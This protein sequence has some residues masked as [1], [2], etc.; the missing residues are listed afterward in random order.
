M[1]HNARLLEILTG[2]ADLDGLAPKPSEG[3]AERATA[4][5]P[6]GV[7]LAMLLSALDG[8]EPGRAST[9]PSRARSRRACASDV[10]LEALLPFA[11]QRNVLVKVRPLQRESGAVTGAIASVLDVTDSARARR[12]LE[13][14]ATFD[15]LTGAHNRASIMD[16][17]ERELETSRDT[18]VVFV[19]LDRFKSIND[20]LGHAAGD[21]VLAQV[22]ERLQ[23]AM[24]SSDE[25][26]RL[27]GDEFLILLRGVTGVPVAMSAAQRISER[28]MGP[29]SCPAARSSCPR[30]SAWRVADGRPITAEELVERA[31]AAMYR[32]KAQRRGIPVFAA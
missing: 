22:A 19:D 4:C 29:S 10:E 12:E 20:S 14:R 25:L 17:L 15:A 26:G 32:S 16:A 21:E 9:R 31:D 1:Y 2:G 8:G 3:I 11:A 23:T 7:A 5:W 28:S 27:G 30:A 18:G 6:R 24:R 13:K